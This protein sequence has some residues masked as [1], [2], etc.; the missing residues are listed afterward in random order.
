MADLE[1]VVKLFI[2]HTGRTDLVVNFDS[3]DY[4]DAATGPGARFYINQAIDFLDQQQETPQQRA[5]HVATLAA[6]DFIVD[7]LNC[8]AV[9][10]VYTKASGVDRLELIRVPFTD[11]LYTYADRLTDT[12]QDSPAYWSIVDPRQAPEQY[13]DAVSSV[14]AEWLMDG[15]SEDTTRIVIMPPTDAALT[16]TIQGLFYSTTLTADTDV[17]WWTQN[18]PWLVVWVAKYILEGALRSSAGM[19]DLLAFIQPYIMGIDKDLV[20]QDMADYAMELGG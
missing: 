3:A 10:K 9:Q 19:K 17:N 11:I 15:L 14:D 12:D 2:E 7:L 20:E 5:T 16:V 1:A 6:G 13:D 18:K 8:R 4:D